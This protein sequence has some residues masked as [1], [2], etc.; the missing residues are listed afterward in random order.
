LEHLS[1]A[2][3]FRAAKLEKSVAFFIEKFPSQK[4]VKKKEYA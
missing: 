3:D 2:I 1:K 4:P